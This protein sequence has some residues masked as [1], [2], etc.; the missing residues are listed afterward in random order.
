MHNRATDFKERFEGFARR[1]IATRDLAIQDFPFDIW[2][3]MAAEGLFDLGALAGTG[4]NYLSLS[5]G[6]EALVR[7]GGNLGMSLSWLMHEL[8]F[9]FAVLGFG[10]PRQQEHYRDLA[11]GRKILCL[12]VSE[13]EKGGHPKYLKT[14]A[15]L[16]GDHYI[17]NGEKTYLTNGPIAS[18][19]IVIA[20]TDN[21][22]GRKRFTAFFVPKDTPGLTVSAIDLPFLKPCP[23]GCLTLVNCPVPP[24]NIL[25]TQGQAYEDLVLPFRELEDAL[26]L[27][28]LTGAMDALMHG[29]AGHTRQSGQANAQLES[30]GQLSAL[31]SVARVL[32]YEAAGRLDNDR[33]GPDFGSLSYIFRNL[34][35]Q[36]QAHAKEIMAAVGSDGQLDAL[37]NDFT[38]ALSFAKNVERLKYIKLGQAVLNQ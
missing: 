37:F 2:E 6:G 11:L 26:M 21:T 19:F 5:M 33:R 30:F 4:G 28:P 27:G 10:N 1:N 32:A 14:S 23:H 15:E 12:A 34:A 7:A 25:G 8:L 16:H 24:A 22:G 29:L 3:A 9:L 18:V 36:F 13:P 17:L 31:T 20:V 38:L 35:R